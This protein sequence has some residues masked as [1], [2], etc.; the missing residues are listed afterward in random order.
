MTKYV[1]D[2]LQVKVI[3]ISSKHLVSPGTQLL[4][5]GNEKRVSALL[6]DEAVS[7]IRS[8]LEEIQGRGIEKQYHTAKG[9]SIV[10]WRRPDSSEMNLK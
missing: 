7:F 9:I 6:T 10:W 4:S 1:N 8:C 3:V 5:N 2:I